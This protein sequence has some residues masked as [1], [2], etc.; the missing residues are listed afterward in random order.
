MGNY[1]TRETSFESLPLET[2]EQNIHLYR[3][4]MD[5]VKSQ[6]HHINNRL[7]EYKDIIKSLIDKNCSFE[8]TF[9]KVCNLNVEHMVDSFLLENEEKEKVSKELSKELSKEEYIEFA[10]FMKKNICNIIE[11]T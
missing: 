7:K 11:E 1:N 2:R 8:Y 4:L 5:N 6:Q 9:R 10:H 3:L